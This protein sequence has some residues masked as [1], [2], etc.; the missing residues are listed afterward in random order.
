MKRVAVLIVACAAVLR[1]QALTSSWL[2]F[3]T[4]DLTIE[5]LAAGK[6][7][8]SWQVGGVSEALVLMPFEGGTHA[9]DY[10]GGGHDGAVSGGAVWNATSG[11]DS[12]GAYTLDGTGQVSIAHAAAFNVTSGITVEAWIYPTSLAGI[13]GIVDRGYS[14]AAGAWSLYLDAGNPAWATATVSSRVKT[15]APTMTLS[16]NAWHHLVG[17]FS[18]ATGEQVLYVDGVALA[19]DDRTAALNSVTHDILIGNGTGM[20]YFSGRVDDVAIYNRALSKEEVASHYQVHPER[21]KHQ[22]FHTGESWRACV[23]PNDGSTDGATVCTDPITL[24]ASSGPSVTHSTVS[25]SVRMASS[26]TAS[27]T[28]QVRPASETVFRV[29]APTALRSAWGLQ[30]PATYVFSL[31]A[32][33]SGLTASKAATSAGPWSAL[34]SKTTDDFFNG[35]EAVRWDYAGNRAYVSVAFAG[36]DSY[37]VKLSTV[38]A[39][40]VGVAKYYDNRVAAFS[41]SMD[42]WT[43]N[44]STYTSATD[45][46]SDKYRAAVEM[47]RALNIPASVG[48]ISGGGAVWANM[49]AELTA[50]ASAPCWEPASHSVTHQCVAGYSSD[51]AS[52]KA[53]ILASLTGIPYGQYVYEYIIPCGWKDSDL[54]AAGAHTYLLMREWD[55]SN[56]PTSIGFPLWNPAA[57]NYGPAG[58]VQVLSWDPILEARAPKGRYDAADVA[59][60]NAAWDATYALGG[61]HWAMYHPDR[62]IN[63]VINSTDAP[64]SGT[65]SSLYQHLSYVANR[66]DVWYA[67]NGWLALYRLAAENVTVAPAGAPEYA[68]PASGTAVTHNT[69]PVGTHTIVAQCVDAAGYRGESTP[70]SA[71][72]PAITGTVVYGSR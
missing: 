20:G 70:T 3:A 26:R 66:K 68:A 45:D 52:S 19:V 11:H 1:G 63:S 64:G 34:T 55:Q 48:I 7:V 33:S 62:Y 22:E 47:V 32:G 35:V 65:A 25:G 58:S 38:G 18:Q 36:A 56:H 60:M 69:L 57:A 29:T 16:A 15:I 44:S 27:C 23:T 42:N 51:L 59:A 14:G 9:K 54:V 5:G 30:Y 61:I 28:A 4:E 43:P 50:C 24:V 39:G 40:Y 31:P 2:N 13:Q 6:N 8:I 21:K 10:S 72:V 37:Y 53:T 17:T 12:R 71:V 46:A 41:L 49:Q 67:A